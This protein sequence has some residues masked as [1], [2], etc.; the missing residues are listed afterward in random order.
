MRMWLFDQSTKRATAFLR[1][2]APATMTAIIA[3][4]LV[5]NAIFCTV[6]PRYQRTGSS[7]A[8]DT[9]QPRPASSRSVQTG[10]ASYYGPGFH[11]K[12]TANGERF[13][14]HALTAAHRTLPFGTRVRV[15]NLTNGKSIV[16]RVNDRGPFKK[17]RII[18]LSRE[19]ARKI[20]MLQSG[21]ARVSL[22]VL[23]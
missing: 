6:A 23:P 22:E 10:E 16:V 20:D 18:D 21:T 13:N 7:P 2:A 19:A 9:R 11:G 3:I 14:M 4:A 1:N 12:L 15:T 8:P 17:N 5:C